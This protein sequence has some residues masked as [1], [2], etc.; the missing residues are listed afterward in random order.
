M[1]LRAPWLAL[2]ALPIL[3]SSARAQNK[4]AVELLP[5]HTLACL[6]LRQPTRLAREI[7]ALVK[8]SALDD[9]PRRL[10]KM[11]EQGQP[12]YWTRSELT[13]LSVFLCP[14]MLEEAGRA[15][16]GFVALTGF[17]KDNMPNVVGV[18][19]SGTSNMPGIFMRA[20]S[21][22]SMVHLVGEVEGVALFREKLR[23]YGAPKPGL[24]GQQ[25]QLQERDSGPVVGRLPGLILFGSSVDSF[26]DVIRRAKGKSVESSLTSLRAFKGS[27]ALREKPGLFAY[28]DVAALLAK[29]GDRARQADEGGA[30]VEKGLLAIL[31]KDALRNLI[32]SLTLH[33]GAL[34]GRMR[35]DL[36]AK[37]DSPLLGLLPD[38]PAPRELLHFAPDDALLALAGGLGGR[39]KRWKTLVNLLD[40]FYELE[41]RAGDNRPSRVIAE[42]E[43]KL[44]FHIDKDVL[45]QVTGAG[46]IVAKDWRIKPGQGALLLL[47]ARDADAA[48]KLET[49]GLPRLFSLGDNDVTQPA[50]SEVGG[51]KIKTLG[52]DNGAKR[53]PFAVHYGRQGAVVVLGIHAERVAEALERGS[54]K[55]GLLGEAKVAEAVKDIDDKAV[56][57]GVVSSSQ[58]ALEVFA[59]LSRPQVMMRAPAGAP[60]QAVERPAHN[61]PE[62]SKAVQAFRQAGEPLVFGLHRQPDS[63]VLEMRPLSLRRMTPLLLEAWIEAL[64]KPSGVGEGARPIPVPVDRIKR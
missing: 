9:L 64:L 49:E 30:R 14:E 51:R 28:V 29:V 19:Q 31:G 45:A 1:S 43:K 23:M 8:G 55:K 15:R 58:M 27:A 60:P 52:E 13:A 36:D 56:A 47:R 39:E 25:P 7:A 63:L 5:A 37:G 26:K 57:V 38:G 16:G 32:F 44:N 18:L 62:D 3:V 42:M 61:L 50:E 34:E 33:N 48:A 17:G 2:L 35:C 22:S 11:R 40:A 24:P 6:E 12:S 20:F 46:F 53:F 10:A 54:K 41:G 21:T 4:G 59:A